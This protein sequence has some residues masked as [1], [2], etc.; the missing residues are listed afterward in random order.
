MR[1]LYASK[2]SHTPAHRDK[3]RLLA[4][5]VELHAVVPER[6]NGAPLPQGDEADPPLIALPTLFQGH[7]H[8]HV[9]RGFSGVAARARPDLI[10]MDEEPYS[11]VTWQ[12]ARV[13]RRLKVPFVF[14]AWQNVAKRYPPPFGAMRSAVFRAAA[15]GIAFPDTVDDLCG[16]PQ[17]NHCR[18]TSPR[19]AD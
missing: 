18:H 7:N 13:A 1:V 4:E 5:R 10:H 3:L 19:R 17:G 12:G 15:G 14:F 9:Y 8:F 2:A 6:W 11:A 16:L